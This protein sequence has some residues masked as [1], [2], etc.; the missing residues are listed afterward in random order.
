VLS[1]HIQLDI[2]MIS[3][4]EI[5]ENFGLFFKESNQTIDD[6]TI[7]MTDLEAMDD[8]QL[9]TIYKAFEL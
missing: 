4:N 1:L 2:K 3:R 8:N 5:L 9:L 7:N 6:A